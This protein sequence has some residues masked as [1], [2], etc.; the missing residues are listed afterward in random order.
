M[1]GAAVSGRL[2]GRWKPRRQIRW[3][4]VIMLG[5][6]LANVALNATLAPSAASFFTVS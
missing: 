1:A 2:A 3:G 4:F 6:A 5:C